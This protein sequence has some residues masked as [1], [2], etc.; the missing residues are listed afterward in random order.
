MFV[1]KK[2]LHSD[3]KP[4]DFLQKISDSEEYIIFVPNIRVGR[5]LWPEGNGVSSG[6]GGEGVPGPSRREEDKQS[7]PRKEGDNME[8]EEEGR[9]SRSWWRRASVHRVSIFKKAFFNNI[10]SVIL[11]ML[12]LILHLFQENKSYGVKTICI[13]PLPSHHHIWHNI[14]LRLWDLSCHKNSHLL[15]SSFTLLH[16]NC[17][18]LLQRY[19]S[20]IKP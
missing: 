3:T 12:K 16:F 7:T 20:Y 1:I 8:Q 18:C 5:C 19:R 13:H 14:L 6:E 10:I 9:T 4:Q 17:V 11:L 2:R 15:S